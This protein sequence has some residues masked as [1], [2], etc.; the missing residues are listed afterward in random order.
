MRHLP[1]I[2]RH[3][4][5]LGLLIAIAIHAIAL[6]LH[7]RPASTTPL[8]PQLQKAHTTIRMALQPTPPVIIEKQPPPL[9]PAEKSYLIEAPRPTEQK[10]PIKPK[11]VKAPVPTKTQHTVRS[12]T[13]ESKPERPTPPPNPQTLQRGISSEAALNGSFIPDYPRRS[14]QR[15]E[16]G[17]VTL[18][19]QVRADGSVSNVSIQKSS[20][21]KRL[22]S[23]ALEGIRQTPFKPAQKNGRAIASTIQISYTF[24]LTN[25]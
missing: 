10:D 16:E 24:R 19:V 5:L 15:G 7:S 12:P 14:R 4:M 11:T 22:D 3:P 17:T 6:R 2:T 13:E 20:G 18:S 21:H 9:E 8:I 1:S 23:A 25:D